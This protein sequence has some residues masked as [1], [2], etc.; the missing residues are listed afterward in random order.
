MT[1]FQ[2]KTAAERRDEEET[3][4]FTSR[5]TTL[6][7]WTVFTGLCIILIFVLFV[8]RPIDI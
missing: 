8:I 2:A 1:I 6:I 4:M 5:A 7:V 3:E